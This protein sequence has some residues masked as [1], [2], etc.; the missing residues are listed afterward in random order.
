[1]WRSE[2]SLYPYQRKATELMLDANVL[3]AF[4]MG[5]GKTP[6]TLAAIEML[7]ND[8]EIEGLG[9]VVVPASLKWQW[10]RE[11][12]K[13]TDQPCA[14]IDGP[15]KK[16]R[17]QYDG[18][19]PHGYMVC[20]YNTFVSD[21]D[22]LSS[23]NAFL[24]LDEA[25]AIKGF[26]TKRTRHIKRVRKHYPVRFA[27]TGT[28][29][30]NG[31]AEEIFSI[32]EWVEPEVLGSFWKFDKRYIRRNSMG[33]IDGYKNVREL[34][35]RI[36]ANT[37][38]ATHKEPEVAAFLPKVLY[39]DPYLV[40][41]DRRTKKAVDAISGA[42]SDDLDQL[43]DEI[44]Q[45]QW[46]NSWRRDHPDGSVMAKIQVLRMLLAHPEAVIEAASLHEQAGGTKTF[47]LEVM[48]SGVLEGLPSPKMDAA[49]A[50]ISD[51]LD[52]DP[53]HKAVVFSTFRHPTHLLADALGRHHAVLFHGGLSSAKRD[54]VKQRFVSDPD[55][56]VFVST[57]AGGYGLDL[58]QANLLVNL[59]LPWQAGLLQQ[60]NARIRRASSEW[61]FVVVQD[62]LMEGTID[63]RIAQMIGQKLALA[64]ALVDGEDD[65]ILSDI[66]SLRSFLASVGE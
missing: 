64:E 66:G 59:D 9:T 35:R 30:E 63:Q 41:M 18:L 25:T 62:F 60:R 47:A 48:M 12:A 26:D 4:E 42:I 8:G 2:H 29:V 57:D 49:A 38:R 15:L 27:L 44:L 20:S 39:R 7:R 36:S 31:K 65:M 52:A 1:M 17:Q 50:Y 3:L 5:C 21:Y 32:M 33:W 10:A 6:T 45:E 53:A 54:A 11:I 43:A 51:H 28:P 13:F 58:P 23:A 24:V 61:E 56:R 37:V 55:C 14:V 16:R 19:P 40:P 46:H 22:Y 34:H